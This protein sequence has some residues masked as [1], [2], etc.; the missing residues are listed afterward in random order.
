ME[1]GSIT[2]NAS[3][4]CGCGAEIE[5]VLYA[6]SDG[7][8]PLLVGIATRDGRCSDCYSKRIAWKVKLH[9]AF[10][11]AWGILRDDPPW[12]DVVLRDGQVRK[13]IKALEALCENENEE[14]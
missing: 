8:Q 5:V 2:F 13:L 10:G 6:E 11:D 1:E 9:R 14:N 12:K 7:R 3:C 4:D